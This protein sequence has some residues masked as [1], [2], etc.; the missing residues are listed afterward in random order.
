MS[1]E[2]DSISSD[3][4]EA[5][6]R[7][8]D[9]YPLQLTKGI[10]CERPE[11]CNT[12]FSVE[13]RRTYFFNVDCNWISFLFKIVIRFNVDTTITK[14]TGGWKSSAFLA[15][16]IFNQSPTLARLLQ[17]FWKPKVGIVI[18][19]WHSDSGID[20]CSWLIS[21]IYINFILNSDTILSFSSNITPRLGILSFALR[22]SGSSMFVHLKTLRNDSIWIPSVM[23]QSHSITSIFRES[24][25]P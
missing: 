1:L 7:L 4:L 18:D 2:L 11:A 23:L 3:H 20:Q 16:E 5:S 6:I 8:Q 21:L 17:I 22:V 25:F 15:A 19:V 10:L 9:E 14:I 13:R 12:V 24:I